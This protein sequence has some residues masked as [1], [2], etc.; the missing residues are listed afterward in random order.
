MAYRNCCLSH[1][2][3][4]IFYSNAFVMGSKKFRTLYYI[5]LLI[6]IWKKLKIM[7]LFFCNLYK[8]LDLQRW[9]ICIHILCNLYIS[10][11]FLHWKLCKVFP[12]KITLYFHDY[13]WQKIRFV[14]LKNF[15][16]SFIISPY[17]YNNPMLEENLRKI[18]KHW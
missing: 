17:T 16:L 9:V 2:V 15:I 1:F 8:N 12:N 11:F 18:S 5:L 4:K 7:E 6:L 13:F 3:F 14:K 10:S